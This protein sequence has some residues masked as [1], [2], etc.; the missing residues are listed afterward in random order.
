MG[1]PVTDEFYFHLDPEFKA[2]KSIIDVI[3]KL[4]KDR[5]WAEIDDPLDR[6]E[7]FI[8]NLI[9]SVS[10]PMAY[11]SSANTKIYVNKTPYVECAIEKINPHLKNG[12]K[13][14]YC[15]KDGLNVIQSS[16]HTNMGAVQNGE[17][18]AQYSKL[19]FEKTVSRWIWSLESME[20]FKSSHPKNVLLF[21]IDKLLDSES[22]RTALM[23][24][25]KFC[26]F[27]DDAD[28]TEFER[29]V[30]EW[31]PINRRAK[32]QYPDFSDKEK[33]YLLDSEKFCNYMIQYGYEE[34]L[35]KLK[36]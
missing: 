7:T 13:L 20:T 35:V 32:M 2:V 6:K 19:E 25:I 28:M 31:P 3:D 4:I 8:H 18:F 27:Q 30:K 29:L 5:P 17:E 1:L 14:I 15:L 21:Q 22:R 24:I 16:I 10:H 26:D 34:S 9:R 36:N 23:G 12:A 33:K 11:E